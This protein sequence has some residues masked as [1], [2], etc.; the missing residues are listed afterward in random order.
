[1]PLIFG[2]VEVL[3]RERMRGKYWR[4]RKCRRIRSPRMSQILTREELSVGWT[5]GTTRS[6][7]RPRRLLKL[8]ARKQLPS[9]YYYYT[10]TPLI[11]HTC[12]HIHRPNFPP[13]SSFRLLYSSIGCLAQ[14]LFQT[15]RHLFVVISNKTIHNPSIDHYTNRSNP[16][17]KSLF[18]PLHSTSIF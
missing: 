15:K 5:N 2:I 16:I 7:K 6:R 14:N 3:R 9:N 18:H 1:M 8:R 13:P 11:N 4:V 12:V 17:L 10:T